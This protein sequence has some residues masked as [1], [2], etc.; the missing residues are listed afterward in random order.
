MFPRGSR[1]QESM[2]AKSCALI[3]ASALLLPSILLS[4]SAS[5]ICDASLFGNPNPSNCSRLLLDNR[6]EGNHGLE[7]KDRKH[8]LFY[9]GEIELRPS[10]ITIAEWRNRVNFAMTMS[11]GEC[12]SR[13]LCDCHELTMVHHR[14]LQHLPSARI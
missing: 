10:D 7:S 5:T 13:T 4:C 3:L 2:C 1:T 8:H 11:E 12:A 14:W 9:T 6:A